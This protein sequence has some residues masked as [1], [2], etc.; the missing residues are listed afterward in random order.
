M[1]ARYS[2]GHVIDFVRQLEHDP[3]EL[4]ILGD[5]SQRKSYLDVS[6][7]VT[8]IISRITES[9]QYE[10]FNLGL[11]DY[12][13]VT[14]SAGWICERM[15][16]K[17]NITYTGGDRGWIGDNPFILLSIERI[18]ATGWTPQFSIRQAV[19]RTVDYLLEHPDCR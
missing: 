4:T 16:L 19:E 8:A 1:G 15:G 14:D 11:A 7:C 9:P 2:H 12:C 10:V 3:A 6:D 17:P 18:S 13:T 5:G